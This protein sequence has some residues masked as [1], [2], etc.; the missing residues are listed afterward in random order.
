MKGPMPDMIY[1]GK[2]AYI[3]ATPAALAAEELRD[4]LEKALPYT[5]MNPAL[6]ANIRGLLARTEPKEDD[7]E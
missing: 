4:S 5:R 2:H 6:S 7:D 3:L 1:V